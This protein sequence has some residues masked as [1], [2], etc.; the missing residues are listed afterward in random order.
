MTWLNF[1]KR[2]VI[3]LS[4]SPEERPTRHTIPVGTGAANERQFYVHGIPHLIRDEGNRV[5]HFVGV[6][7]HRLQATPYGDKLLPE[8]IP[9]WNQ[10]SVHP[11]EALEKVAADVIQAVRALAPDLPTSTGTSPEERRV[12]ITRSVDGQTSRGKREDGEREGSGSAS[13]ENVSSSAYTVGKLIQWGEMEFPNRK[14]GGPR[15]Y[16][17]FAVKLYTDAGEKTLQGEGLK[18]ALAEAG[19]KQGDRVAV[20]RLRKEKVP[21][22]D[23]KTGDPIE[24]PRTGEQKLWDRWV[25]NINLVH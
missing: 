23:K 16:T 9:R 15:I 6:F 22:F 12:Q 5:I 25:W 24:D 2:V 17:S 1:L 20:K 10:V 21:A 4:A 19:C 7:H 18:D 8:V 3:V 11:G 14:S 13:S